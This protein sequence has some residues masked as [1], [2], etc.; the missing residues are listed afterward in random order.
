MEEM[1]DILSSA[2][3][4]ESSLDYV[5]SDIAATRLDL[6]IGPNDP[7]W[8]KKHKFF[9]KRLK[10]DTPIKDI[11]REDFTYYESRMLMPSDRAD[12]KELQTANTKR[13]EALL[14]DRFKGVEDS[15]ETKLT[16]MYFG[17]PIAPMEDILKELS[18]AVGME[19]EVPLYNIKPPMHFLTAH[20]RRNWGKDS[21]KGKLTT[22][23][24]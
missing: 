11:I 16:M 8:V 19:E 21:L 18:L 12:V 9:S 6:L 4:D 23:P 5:P 14:N 24:L 15:L 7:Q 13:Y 2:S 17:L 20:D 1:A 22:I 3:Q 10:S